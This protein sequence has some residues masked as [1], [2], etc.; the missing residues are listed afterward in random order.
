[1]NGE[2]WNLAPLVH[3][4]LAFR[5]ER[6]W[7]QFHRPKELAAALAIEAGELQEIFLWKEMETAEEVLRDRERVNR[8]KEELADCAIFLLL[9]ANDLEIDLAEAVSHKIDANAR[10]Y[11]ADRHR[12]R[13]VKAPH[14]GAQE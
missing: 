10:R 4:L 8:V 9:L 5:D 1:M 7:R 6:N 14:R 13:A 3:R 11:P 12:G 2:R